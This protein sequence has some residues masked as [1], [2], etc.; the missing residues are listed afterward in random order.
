MDATLATALLCALLFAF[1]LKK[2]SANLSV[3]KGLWHRL[4]NRN[5]VYVGARLP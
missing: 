3:K 2:R 4:R 5:R 1:I